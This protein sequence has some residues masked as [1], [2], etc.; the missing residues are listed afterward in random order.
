MPQLTALTYDYVEGMLDKRAPHRDG[1]L[2]LAREW[3]EDGRLVWAGALGDP[4]HG[5]FFAFEVDDAAE[6]DDFVAADPYVAAGLVTSRL[7]EPY[8]L[9]LHRK[10]HT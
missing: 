9:I 2:A 3:L 6:V 4:P 7:I 1:H 5:A 10:L 8:K